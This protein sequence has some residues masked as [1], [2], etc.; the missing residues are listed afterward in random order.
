MPSLPIERGDGSDKGRVEWRDEVIVRQYRFVA[1]GYDLGKSGADGS[2]G[3]ATA[4]AVEKFAATE[5]LPGPGGAAYDG[6]VI[7]GLIE[8]R[9]LARYIQART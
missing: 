2:Y 5:K 7:D 4:A 9:M 8:T 3:D 1:L 6:D